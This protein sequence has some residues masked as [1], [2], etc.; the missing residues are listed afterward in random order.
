MKAKRMA[1]LTG[2]VVLTMIFFPGNHPVVAAPST[3]EITTVTPILGNETPIPHL[4]T[5]HG[6]DYIQLLYDHLLGST[7]EGKFSA[8]HGL[9]NKWEMSPDGLTWTFYLKRGIKFHDGVEVTAKDVKFSIDLLLRPES[10][11]SDAVD[12]KQKVKGVEVKDSYTVVVHC[13]V[14]DIFV[15]NYLSTTNPGGMVVPKDYYERVGKDGFQKHPIGTGP[16]K[17]HSQQVGSFIKLEAIDKHWRD[18]VPRYKYMTYRIIPE[19]STR[20][21]M[22]KTGAADIARI[23]RESVKDALSSG[24]NVLSKEGYAVLCYIPNVQWTSPVFSDIRFRK[25]LNLAIDRE[26]I[27]KH[28][29]A[30]LAK[31]AGAWPGSIIST[32]GGDPTLK[33]YSYDPQEARRLIKEG[34]W[35][36]H[37]FTLV[38]FPR[39]S[40]PEIERITEAVAGYWEK[41]GLRPKIRMTEWAVWRKAWRSRSRECENTIQGRDDYTDLPSIVRGFMQFY[42]SKWQESAVNL[43]YLNERFQRIEKSLDFGEISRLLVEVYRYSYDQYLLAPICET[44][45]IFSTSKKIPKWDLG[46]RRNDRNYQDLIRQR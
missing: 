10:S 30:G 18:G 7:P 3:G 5:G 33:P 28:I 6:N 27:I 43:P 34:G 15:G 36:G 39:E 20:M 4:E 2:A 37:E 14:P 45:D 38:S 44:S 16:Y 32:L 46:R 11:T 29:L 12:L 9:S 40:L 17:W 26:A 8:D 21:A 35:E 1:L 41:I 31:P 24:M 22:L 13:K 23:S 19:E 42:Y 25:A